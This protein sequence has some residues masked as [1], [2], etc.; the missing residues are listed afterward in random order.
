MEQTKE[1]FMWQ[2]DRQKDITEDYMRKSDNK[3]FPIILF[4]KI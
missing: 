1:V 4:Q 2:R 3:D